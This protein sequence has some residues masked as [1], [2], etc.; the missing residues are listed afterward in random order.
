[1][2]RLRRRWSTQIRQDI[3]EVIASLGIIRAQ[4][5]GLSVARRRLRR[6]A[7]VQN[8][9]EVVV[10]LRIIRSEPHGLAAARFGLCQP[11]D[12]KKRHAEIVVSLGKIRPEAQ[13]LPVARL[14]LCQPAEVQQCIAKVV[15][16]VW[17]K[18]ARL[19]RP[20][21][22]INRQLIAP[23]LMGDDTQQMQSVGMCRIGGQYLTI[24]RFGLLEAAGL[25]LDKT[26]LQQV[27]EIKSSRRIRPATLLAVQ[28]LIGE[29]W[30]RRS[31]G[32]SSSCCRSTL[33][34]VHAGNPKS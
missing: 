26:A 27:G 10:S 3:A 32:L 21:N 34:A 2:A 19:D 30:A 31:R 15:V 13:R 17:M 24:P 12:T 5:H 7:Q 16:S 8:I 1:V 4:T 23:N 29:L 20:A 33:L 25:M 14:R 28:S 18:T 9:A 6:S 22:Q 11:S